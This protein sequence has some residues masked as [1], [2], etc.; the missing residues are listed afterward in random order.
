MEELREIQAGG[1]A[2]A[3]WQRRCAVIRRS[4]CCGCWALA[5]GVGSGSSG[6]SVCGGASVVARPW[7]AALRPVSALYPGNAR[8]ASGG[9]TGHPY[10]LPTGQSPSPFPFISH[11]LLLIQAVCSGGVV[12]ELRALQ[13]Q[14]PGLGY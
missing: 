2:G 7:T 13:L 5:A 10:P 1:G 4:A 12:S 6:W 11:P 8:H 9:S 3:R 14:Q